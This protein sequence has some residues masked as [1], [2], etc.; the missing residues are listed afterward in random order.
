MGIP[1]GVSQADREDLLAPLRMLDGILEASSLLVLPHNVIVIIKIIVIINIVITVV[2]ILEAGSL[3]VL[4]H[5]SIM[6]LSLLLL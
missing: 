1:G 2:L 6:I 4:P 3:L 5:S